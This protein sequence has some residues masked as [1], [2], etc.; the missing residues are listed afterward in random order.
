[1][2]FFQDLTLETRS[3]GKHDDDDEG[4]GGDSTNDRQSLAVLAFFPESFAGDATL[5]L[6]RALHDR[7]LKP[8]MMMQFVMG[9]TDSAS[10]AF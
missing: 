8:K 1:M 9:T 6:E 10:S 7:N 3:D 5:N 2:T 4:D